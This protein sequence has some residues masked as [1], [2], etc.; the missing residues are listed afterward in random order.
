MLTKGKKKKIGHESEGLKN[1]CQDF[2]VLFYYS[3]K[4]Y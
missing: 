1:S 4:L 3:S 2:C